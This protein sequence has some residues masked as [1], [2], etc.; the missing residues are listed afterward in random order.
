[1][2]KLKNVRARLV[3]ILFFASILLSSAAEAYSGPS[4]G[5]WEEVGP[6]NNSS[7]AFGSPHFHSSHSND[8]NVR[9]PVQIPDNLSE[10]RSVASAN[11]DMYIVQSGDTLPKI[12]MKVYGD[13]DK[14][15]DLMVINNLENGNRIYVGQ[16]LFIN[17]DDSS[18]TRNTNTTEQALS[19]E[20][21]RISSMADVSDISHDHREYYQQSKQEFEETKSKKTYTIQRGD[22]LG[23]IAYRLLGSS[24]KWNRIAQANPDINPDRLF[25][26]QNIIIPQTGRRQEI[27]QKNIVQK[28]AQS[29]SNSSNRSSSH[30]NIPEDIITASPPN[31]QFD[32]A[33]HTVNNNNSFDAQESPSVSGDFAPPPMPISFSGGITPPPPPPPPST[34]GRSPR[35]T[36]QSRSGNQALSP[37]PPPPISRPVQQTAPHRYSSSGQPTP[38]PPIVSTRELYAEERYRLPNELKPTTFSPYF[39]NFNGFHGLFDVESALVPYYPTWHFGMHYRYRNYKYL[40]GKKDVVSGSEMVVPLHLA[41]TGKKLFAG[42]TVPFQNWKVNDPNSNNSVSLSG[43][44]DPS[45]KVGYQLWQNLDGTHA[46]TIHTKGRFSSKNHHQPLVTMDGKSRDGVRVGPAEA[47]RGSWGQLGA[48]YSGQFTD[49]W[50]S[51]INMALANNSKDSITQ[52][53]IRGGLDYRVNHN[54]SIATEINSTSYEM[55]NGR[56]GTNVDMNLGFLLFNHNWQGSLVFDV[57]LQRKWGYS[58]DYGIVLG[59]NHR[60]E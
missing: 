21:T 48:A 14:W 38:P 27:S 2:F 46:V 24:H 34:S 15:Q 41:Y 1:M 4:F 19:R 60:W 23:G 52:M 43:L 6:A 53:I 39:M 29:N 31:F 45:L 16:K 28:Q 36:P 11:Q 26:G 35:P 49:R 37:P 42:V 8:S 22:T 50:T 12:A 13:P 47:T 51:H 20:P 55:D 56:D 33:S 32:S 9:S 7:S 18:V 25:V 3:L 59:L 40:N 44:H 54:F 5:E 57:N 30:R 10:V 17:S 58:H